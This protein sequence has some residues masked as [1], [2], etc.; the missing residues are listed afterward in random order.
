MNPFKSKYTLCGKTASIYLGQDPLSFV[1][2]RVQQVQVS[3]AGFEGDKH[4]GATL[5]SGGRTPHYPRGT[6]I[7]NDRQV[8]IVSMEELETVARNL[9]LPE[10]LPEWLGANLLLQGIPKLA[11]LPTGTRLYFSG[12]VTLIATG[13]NQPCTGPGKVIQAHYG[14][15]GLE[16]HFAKA[17][18]HRRGIVA[19]VEKPGLLIEGEEV[20]VEIPEQ[21][22]YSPD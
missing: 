14:T 3:F 21:V 19:M 4:S 11:S 15:P 1:T 5:R 16:S 10:V 22:L 13:E 18:M 12:G 8:S 2:T 6:E 7:V 17:A 20:R 9:D